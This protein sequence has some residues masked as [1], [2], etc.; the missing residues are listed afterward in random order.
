[1]EEALKKGPK[2]LV[3]NRG[4]RRYLAAGKGAFEIDRA[5]VEEEARYDGKFVLRTNLEMD[6]GEVAAKY[7]QLWRVERAFRTVKSVIET[8]PIY[9]KCDETILGHVFCSFLALV[10]MHELD[11]RLA[12]KGLKLEW[13]DVKQDL[14]ALS[15]VEVFDGADAYWLRTEFVGVTGK[16]FQALGIAAPPTCRPA[17]PPRPGREAV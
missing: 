1:V 16:V 2:A 3:G 7:K 5:K 15:E 9:H 11:A 13:E 4:Y 6:A 8:R 14:E 12:A 10:V 17:N